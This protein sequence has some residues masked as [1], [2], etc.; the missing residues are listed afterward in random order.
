MTDIVQD[1]SPL[2]TSPTK[3]GAEALKPTTLSLLNDLETGRTRQ[4]SK[5]PASTVLNAPP[6][7]GRPLG[8]K[9]KPKDEPPDPAKIRAEKKKKR[10][11]YTTR[12]LEDAN[13]Q[14]LALFISM[15][16]PSDKVYKPGM[17]PAGDTESKKYTPLGSRLTIS[18]FQAQT[19]A[20]FLVDLEGSDL[21]GKMVGAATDSVPAMVVKGL[22]VFGIVVQYVRGVAP[23][24]KELQQMKLD[25]ETEN[26]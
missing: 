24:L 2:T 26:A 7:R 20:S 1:T 13:D 4:P 21:G 8:S 15:G 6:R 3:L 11:E 12:I 25:M 5:V 22:M 16:V 9:N 17:E 14:I 10:D 23:V 19:V 18:R